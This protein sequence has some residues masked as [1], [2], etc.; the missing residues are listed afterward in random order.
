MNRIEQRLNQNI[1]NGV[2]S[3][4]TY[5][6]AGLPNYDTT[7]KL[8]K[9]QEE[10]GIDVIEIGVPF[11]D[12]IADGPVIQQASF[13][14]IQNGATID[15][16]FVMMKE[17]REKNVN[18]P[19]VFMLYYNTIL[20]Y[21]PEEFAVQCKACGVDGLIVPD[22]PMEEQDELKTFLSDDTIL[23]QLV[24]PVSNDRVDQILSDAK[25]FVYCVSSM[26]VTGQ[27]ADFHKEVKNYLSMIKSKSK[28]PVMMGFG[29]RDAKDVSPFISDIDGAI[30]GTHFI[31]LMRTSNYDVKV[32]SDYV[33]KF[34]QDLNNINK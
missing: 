12:P 26:G 17:L 2:K 5:M 16:T 15:K 11:S 24:S 9:A 21:G 14:A 4:I 19:I 18:V 23:I 7:K 32:A 20:H 3:F 13:E 33:T 10:A 29:I 1:S 6:T 34:K 8:V 22:L 27:A 31:D 30:V 28:I 25:G